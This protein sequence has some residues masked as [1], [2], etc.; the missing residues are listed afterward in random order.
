M[1]QY[2]AVSLRFKALILTGG[3]LLTGAALSWA[4]LGGDVA[5]VQADQVHMQGSRR[6]TV[7]QAYTVHEIQAGTGT[8]IREYVSSSGKVFAVAF[9]GPWLP[10]MR[11]LLG[12]YFEQYSRAAQVARDSRR[13]G[14]APVMIN[15]PGLTVQISGHPRAY[16]GRAFVPEMLPSGVRPEDIQ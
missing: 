4:S 12:N 9:K 7:A 16:G 13:R 15:A 10:D 8:V 1:S 3:F 6:M 14:R 2:Q 5:S 11:Q